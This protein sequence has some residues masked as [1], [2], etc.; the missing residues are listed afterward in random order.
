MGGLKVTRPVLNLA[1]RQDLSW[2]RQLSGLFRQALFRAI[3]VLR[4][5]N[6]VIELTVF[7]DW[8]YRD[9]NPQN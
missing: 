4:C 5:A 3:A 9:R 2:I 6:T 8:H 1:L 7:Y